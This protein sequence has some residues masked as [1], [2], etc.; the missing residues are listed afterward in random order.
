MPSSAA[1]IL[2]L[3]AIFLVG[4]ATSFL[5]ARLLGEIAVGMALGPMLFDVLPH[6]EAFETVGFLGLTL[7]VMEGGL[8]VKVAGLRDIGG[9]AVLVA[10]TG[11][12]LPC[13]VGWLFHWMFGGSDALEGFAAGTALSSTSIGMATEMLRRS[14]LLGSRVG[15]LICVAAIIDDVLSLVILSVLGALSSSDDVKQDHISVALLILRPIMVSFGVLLISFVCIAV[16]PVCITM[17]TKSV[18]RDVRE[19]I[20]VGIL[21]MLTAVMT[22]SSGAVG[23]TPILG[24]FA[25]GMAFSSVHGTGE[26]WSRLG[27]PLSDWLSSIFFVSVGCVIP[28]GDLAKP[29]FV[30]FGVSYA[31][32]AIVCKFL[33]GACVF[34]FT[35]PGGTSGKAVAALL[36]GCAM[37][38][39]GELGYVMSLEAYEGEIMGERAYI[40]C[41]WALS[42]ATA[43][44]PLMLAAALKLGAVSH[45]QPEESTDDE[46]LWGDDIEEFACVPSLNLPV[47]HHFVA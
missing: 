38:G 22:L 5:H 27:A 41:I 4:R 32:P 29:D 21:V 30:L 44:S 25:A 9:P 24:A 47:P 19:K 23:T 45:I 11:T 2:T 14:K 7:L 33:T 31:V 35:W 12:L 16:I 40:S 13:L 26:A 10:V 42:I 6:P 34:L 20:V 36:C 8:S 3:S 39:R 46:A 28:A 15:R 37:V 43:L 1:L 18:D 17:I